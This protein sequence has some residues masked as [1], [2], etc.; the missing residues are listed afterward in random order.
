M[1]N[2]DYRHKMFALIEAWSASGLPQKKWCADQGITVHRFQ[3][4]NSRYKAERHAGAAPAFI[5]VSLPTATFQ[6]VAELHY[7]DGRRLL[8]HSGIDAQFL[9]TLLA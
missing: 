3:Y 2:V 6:P 8:I 9:K 1:L 4:W 5:P 7:P